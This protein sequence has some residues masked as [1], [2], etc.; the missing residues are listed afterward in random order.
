MKIY[1]IVLTRLAD[2]D[3]GKIYT[4]IANEFGMIYA[5][6][7]RKKLLDFLYVLAKY[8][9]IGRPAKNKEFLRVFIFR[10]KNKIIYRVDDDTISI[11]RI[12]N[13][14]QKISGSY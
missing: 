1:K 5:D 6:E 4:Y 14:K 10:K 7:F 8:P 13:Q 11:I 12:L 2:K 3:E 9:F